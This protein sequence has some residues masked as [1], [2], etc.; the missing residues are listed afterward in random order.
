MNTDFLSVEQSQNLQGEIEL[1]GAK[2]AVLVIMTSLLLTRGTS[3]LTNVPFSADVL[4]MVDLLRSLGSSIVFD[5]EKK[6]VH[7]DTSTV[8][9]WAVSS[10]IM[11]KMRAS[12]LVMG[13]LLARFGKVEVALPGGDAIGVRPIDYHLKN[14]ARLGV[15]IQ[16]EGD[17]ISAHVAQL[18]ATR[19][20]LEYPSVGATENILMA[21]VLAKGT[22]HIINAALEPEVLDL[23]AVLRKMGAQITIEPA[24]TLIIE[25]V[26]YLSAIEHEIM[27]DRLEAGSLL[28][29]TAAAGGSIT[30]PQALQSSLDLVLYK[31]E[32]MGHTITVGSCGK[33]ITLR[34]TQFPRAV[35]FK[36]GPFPGFPT[37]LQAPMMV[38]QTVASGTS[39][40]EETVFENRF[41][42][43]RELEK[44]G[45]CI[46]VEHNRACITGVEQLYGT[47]VIASDIRAA[48]ALVI[49]GLIAQG[50]TIISAVH[51]WKRGYDSLEKKLVRLGATISMHMQTQEDDMHDIMVREN[52]VNLHKQAN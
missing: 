24:S 19:I 10:T 15:A 31:L 23:I 16:V 39:I 4:L 11:K 20:V 50:T 25:G 7:V 37:D 35:S 48:M 38:L 9:K 34:A 3:Y 28:L 46:K 13:P 51:H 5:K 32:E 27:I 6:S 49:A 14:F 8:T 21:A 26:E 41:L 12:I 47:H 40:I 29:A 44:M 1:A 18:T 30:L 45:A 2:N 42:H 36:T 17:F 33:G 22:T 52:V 43:V